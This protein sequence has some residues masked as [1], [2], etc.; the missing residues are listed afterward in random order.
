MMRP[1]VWRRELSPAIHSL[2][3]EFNR[4]FEE[5]WNQNVTVAPSG[6]P[7]TDLQEA[8]WVP[9]VDLHETPTELILQADLPGVDP[10]TID[11]S[12]TGPVLSIRGE[13]TLTA[14][15]PGDVKLSERASGVFL[16]QIA[17]TDEVDFEKVQA[18]ARN[19]VLTVRLPKR[20]AVKPR[21]IP[22][23]T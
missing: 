9:A 17:L 16:R 11:L 2:Q 12:L 21:T 6:M 10:A 4:L 5:F 23:S 1:S 20:E 3:S 19:G 14:P 18:E 15:N 13:K 7:P 8:S 22:I